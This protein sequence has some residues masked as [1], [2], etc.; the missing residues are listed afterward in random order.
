ME[1]MWKI[2]FPM[3]KPSIIT[4]ILFNFLSFWNDCWWFKGLMRRE[5]KMALWI[6]N[7][8]FAEKKKRK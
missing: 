7:C 4:V 6:Y 3:A 2:I 5:I 1:Q 8:P